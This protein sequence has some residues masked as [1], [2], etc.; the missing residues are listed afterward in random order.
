MTSTQLLKKYFWMLQAFQSGPITKEEIEAR[1]ARASI[2][3]DHANRIPK[4]S[5]FHMKNEIES[6]FGVSIECNNY[7]EYMVKESFNDSDKFHQWLLSSLAIDS[8]VD[9]CN[10]MHGRIMYESIPGGTQFLHPVVEAMRNFCRV[11]IRYDSFKHEAR[12]FLFSPYALRV[13]KQRWYAIGESSDHPGEVRTYAFDRFMQVS[14]TNTHYT[15]PKGFDVEKYFANVYGMTTGNAEDVQDIVIRIAKKGVPYMRTL[16][17]HPSQKEINTTEEYSDF[18]FHLIPNFEFTQEI[19]GRGE[20][21]EVL[22]PQ[23]FRD[24]IAHIVSELHTK[25]DG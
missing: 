2:N 12:E 19:L 13:Y 6:L 5:F 21:A 16:P 24:K 20:E 8:T 22:A 18:Q 11:I 17:L 23:S 7:G 15:I 25:Y 4:S 9:E 1:W 10:N 3:E 14:T